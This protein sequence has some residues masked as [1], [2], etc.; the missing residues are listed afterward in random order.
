MKEAMLY[1]DDNIASFIFSKEVEW[2]NNNTIITIQVLDS[3]STEDYYD[4]SSESLY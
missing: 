3:L 1:D 2:F 4:K